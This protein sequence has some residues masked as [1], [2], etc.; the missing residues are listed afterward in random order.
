[1]DIERLSQLAVER[2]ELP[3][4]RVDGALPA[5]GLPPLAGDAIGRLLLRA[6]LDEDQRA[7]CA[8]ELEIALGVGASA[9]RHAADRPAPGAP[10]R[11]PPD[12]LARLPAGVRVDPGRR[13][14]AARAAQAALAGHVRPAWPGGPAR[15]VGRFALQPDQGCLPASGRVVE[16]PGPAARQTARNQDGAPR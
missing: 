14:A 1:M 2:C 12:L 7:T 4:L 15:P 3:L 9:G 16:G 5:L 11:R 6:V 10:R 13:P 8:A